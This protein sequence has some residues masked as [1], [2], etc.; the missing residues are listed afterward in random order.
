[1]T[2]KGKK[3]YILGTLGIVYA[4]TGFILGYFDSVT[5]LGILFASL[6]AMGLRNGIT[7]EIQKFTTMLP[8]EQLPPQ[9]P[10]LP[11]RQ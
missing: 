5:A 4:I 11:P 2:F 6:T 8:D 3:T 10:P 7:T 1:M 9:A